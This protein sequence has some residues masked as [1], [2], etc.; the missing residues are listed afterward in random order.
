[1]GVGGWWMTRS[2]KNYEKTIRAFLGEGTEFK[3][4]ITFEGTVRV[5]GV[6]DG[7]VQTEDIF[8]VGAAARVKATIRAGAVIIMGKVEGRIEAKERCEIR[9]GSHVKGEVHTPS[10]YIEEG[11]VFEGVCHMTGAEAAPP[12]KRLASAAAKEG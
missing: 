5:D 8:I 11:A 4:V 9:A 3:G 6:L 2:T 1:M 10:I 12:A 7:E